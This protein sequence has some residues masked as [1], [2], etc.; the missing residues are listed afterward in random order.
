MNLGASWLGRTD[1]ESVK[2]ERTEEAHKAEEALREAERTALDALREA[3]RAALEALQSRSVTL[4][5]EDIGWLTWSI[6]RIC[7]HALTKEEE[8]HHHS[9]HRHDLHAMRCMAI[10]AN[11]LGRAP[12]DDTL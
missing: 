3:E 10:T 5:R 1:P 6:L 12:G 7:D 9:V 4:G 11:L 8:D 2:Q